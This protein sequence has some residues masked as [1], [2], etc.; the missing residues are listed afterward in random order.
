MQWLVQL[1]QK[2]G[3]FL[4]RPTKLGKTCKISYKNMHIYGRINIERCNVKG[5]LFMKRCIVCVILLCLLLTACAIGT[6]TPTA[7]TPTTGFVPSTCGLPPCYAKE[8][9][10]E[11]DVCKYCKAPKPTAALTSVAPTASPTTAQTPAIPNMD[12]SVKP[13]VKATTNQPSTP[14]VYVEYPCYVLG[15]ENVNGY[16][17]Y[18]GGKMPE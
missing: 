14:T 9:T 15:H 2:V 3:V 16:C 6:N 12:T 7:T 17:R 5:G 1:K 13:T 11:N 18:C 4:W 8:H 10:Y